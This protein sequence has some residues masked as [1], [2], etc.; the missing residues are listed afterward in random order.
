MSNKHGFIT[1]FNQEIS[2]T[3]SNLNAGITMNYIEYN[4]QNKLNQLQEELEQHP[5]SKTRHL[6]FNLE[7]KTDDPLIQE[8]LVLQW[9]MNVAQKH[10]DNWKVL[11]YNCQEK[12]KIYK[13]NQTNKPKQQIEVEEENNKLRKDLE[14]ELKNYNIEI[15]PILKENLDWIFENTPVDAHLNIE[16]LFKIHNNV[17]N[18]FVHRIGNEYHVA[19][20]RIFDLSDYILTNNYSR[21]WSKQYVAGDTRNLTPESELTAFLYFLFKDGR[22]L[23]RTW[24]VNRLIRI[25]LDCRYLDTIKIENLVKGDM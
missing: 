25:A 23:K 16:T 12:Y 24:D 9:N 14:K 22:K 20:G 5:I 13:E 2:V 3:L 4:L 6:I 17:R 18:R 15:T 11:K 10:Y 1:E 21:F 8:Y 7:D 19:I